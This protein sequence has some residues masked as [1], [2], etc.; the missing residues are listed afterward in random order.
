MA[1]DGPPDLCQR[2][3]VLVERHS[4]RLVQIRLRDATVEER[5][6]RG[7]AAMTLR[8]LIVVRVPV[9]SNERRNT[10]REPR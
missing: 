9:W 5:S 8:T 2:V 10:P 6:N 3:R 7:T 1:C 4:C